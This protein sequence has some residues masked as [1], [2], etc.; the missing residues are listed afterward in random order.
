MAPE[1]PQ[2]A[3][4]EYYDIIRQRDVLRGD[5]RNTYMNNRIAKIGGTQHWAVQHTLRFA[6][7]D[8]EAK[9]VPHGPP[10]E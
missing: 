9:I 4:K 10:M 7:W 6:F 3:K 8:R 5:G 1:L 2:C